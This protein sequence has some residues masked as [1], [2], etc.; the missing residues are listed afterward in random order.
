M[1]PAACS[2]LL[3]LLFA[4]ASA[5]LH[6]PASVCPALHCPAGFQSRALKIIYEIIPT[7]IQSLQAILDEFQS[8]ECDSPIFTPMGAQCNQ[9]IQAVRQ[10]R[11]GDTRGAADDTNERFDAH[12][13]TLTLLSLR[14]SLALSLSL[15]PLVSLLSS[16]LMVAIK[17]EIHSLLSYVDPLRMWVSLNIPRIQDQRGVS[18]QVKEDLVE[19]LHSSKLSGL[20]LCE[21]MLKY[22][23]SRGK[24][25]S[26]AIKFPLSGDHAV[27]IAELDRKQYYLLLNMV[28]QRTALIPTRS[29]DGRRH[30]TSHSPHSLTRDT[31]SLLHPFSSLT[32]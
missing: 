18:V 4:A 17:G 9:S 19:M 15:L 21:A 25:V 5:A 29:D 32:R 28:S 24:L 31:L 3:L 30:G 1:L 10:R 11:E 2:L 8:K 22:H 13:H 12:G 14:S 26:K 6:C 16:Q 7:K 23:V 27:C 20:G